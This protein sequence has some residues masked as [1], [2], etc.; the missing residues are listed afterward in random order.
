MAI[1]AW[2]HMDMTFI[3]STAFYEFIPANDWAEER[4][5]GKPPSKTLLMNQ[6]E[7]GQ[8]YEVVISN[9]Y[10]G[11]FLRYRMHDLVEVTTLGNEKLGINLPQFRFVGRSGDFIDLSGFAGLI[12]ERQLTAALDGSGLGYVDW[13]VSKE[14]H[15]NKPLLHLY[16]ERAAARI[17]NLTRCLRAYTNI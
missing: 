7:V 3:P 10:G 1:Q 8:R 5:L 12:D 14:W 9:F 13:V 15:E 2:D 11:P 6:V 17:Q 16:I 4:L